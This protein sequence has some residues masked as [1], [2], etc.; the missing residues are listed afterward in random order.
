MN[1]VDFKAARYMT[2][3]VQAEINPILQVAM[4]S[5]I[6]EAIAKVQ[7]MDYLQVFELKPIILKGYVKQQVVHRQEVPKHEN[8]FVVTTGDTPI[9]AKVFVIDSDDYVTMLLAEEY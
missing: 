1:L 6:D 8:N 4:W 5:M 9:N 7:K 3:G 2:R